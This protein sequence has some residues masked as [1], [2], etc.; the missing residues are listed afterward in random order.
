MD[1]LP[2][3]RV[4][5]TPCYLARS[6][7]PD[8]LDTP[9]KIAI[10]AAELL[11]AEIVEVAGVFYLTTKYGLIGYREIGRG[12]IDAAHVNPRDVFQGAFLTNAAGVVIFHNHPSGDPEPS[13]DDLSV[14]RRLVKAGEVV[15]INVLDHVIVGHAHRY[16]SFKEAGQL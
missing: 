11:E 3:V 6:G 1:T 12:S 4:L 14:T 5:F 10:L 8:C 13:P 9:L 7:V 15:G 2:V 16:F